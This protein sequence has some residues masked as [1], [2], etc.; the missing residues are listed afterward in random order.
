MKSLTLA[1]M[2]TASM[3]KFDRKAKNEP[4]AP[5]SQKIKKKKSNASLHALE[6]STKREKERNMKIFDMIQK[7]EDLGKYSGSGAKSNVHL[8]EAKLVK[9]ARKGEET[10]RRKTN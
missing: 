8:S 2:S 1:Q 6:S 10:R 3:G 5:N 4:D 7:K 9:K